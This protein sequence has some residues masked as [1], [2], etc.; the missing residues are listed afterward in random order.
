MNNFLS[1]YNMRKV[2]EGGI[3]VCIDN[4]TLDIDGGGYGNLGL[5]VDSCTY[6][7]VGKVYN[8]QHIISNSVTASGKSIY[9]LINDNGTVT[10]Y[11][12]K[13]F[14]SLSDYRKQKLER[15]FSIAELR[16]NISH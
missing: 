14:I 13:R 9:R 1:L 2:K 10:G 16:S 12:S 4:S 5:H 8:V 3:V 6:L 11:Y 15:L 7:T